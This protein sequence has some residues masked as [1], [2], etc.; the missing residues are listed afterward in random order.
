MTKN[1]RR[2]ISMVLA[3]VMVLTTLPANLFAV[4]AAEVTD[5]EHATAVGD[6]LVVKGDDST[7]PD[8][9]HIPGTH[10]EFVSKSTDPTCGTDIHVHNAG[11]YYK[12][13]DHK[14][15]HISTCYEISTAYEVCPD[16]D[17]HAHT[18][19]AN[20][21]DVV[22]INGTNVTWIT[23]H[24]AYPAVY[25]I[26]KAAYDEAY[27]SAPYLKDVAG[28]AAG[29]A[30]IATVT[31]CY[32]TTSEPTLC[33]HTCSELGGSCY[34]KTCIK[35][36]HAAHDDVKCYSY[37]WKL[38]YNT[39][40]PIKVEFEGTNP[41]VTVTTELP[42]SAKYND[43]ITF[44]LSATG[45]A[46][47]TWTAT[48][49]GKDPVQ[50]SA[51]EPTEVTA[52]NITSGTIKV[53]LTSETVPTYTIT[54][55][56]VNKLNGCAYT[57]NKNS[58]LLEGN[59][60]ELTVVIPTDTDS[61]KFTPSVTVSGA[62]AS[63]AGGVITVG[64]ENVTV[65]IDYQPKKLV[66]NNSSEASPVEIPYNFGKGIA[67]QEDAVKEAI[68]NALVNSGS[69]LPAGLTSWEQLSYQY[70]QQNKVTGSYAGESKPFTEGGTLQYEFA[71]IGGT[72]YGYVRNTAVEKIK[73]IWAEGNG[74]PEVF[75]DVYV[76]LADSRPYGEITVNNAAIGN[77]TADDASQVTEDAVRT[78]LSGAISSELLNKLAVTIGEINVV[79]NGMPALV[80][81]GSVTV[82]LTLPGTADYKQTTKTVTIT[83][84][85]PVYNPS[86]ILNSTNCVIKV[87]FDANCTVEVTE[88]NA[89]APGTY[90]AKVISVATGYSAAVPAINEGTL[91][92]QTNGSYSFT[93]EAADLADNA[94]TY[95]LTA[96]A[97]KNSYTVT[98]NPNGGNWS[99][100]A[101]NKVDTVEFEGTVTQPVDPTK[102][103]YTFAGWEPT[104]VTTMGAAN[105][106][107][108]AKWTVNEYTISFDSKG[109]PAV[110]GITKN[111]GESITLP[112]PA[113]WAGYTFLGWYTDEA[114]TEKF[115]GTTMPAGDAI[116]YAK[117]TEAESSISFNTNGGTAVE[118]IEGNYG[119]TVTKPADPTMIGYTFAGWYSD[120]DLT[121]PYTFSTLPATPITVYAKWN[122]NSYT[123]TWDWDG[124]EVGPTILPTSANYGE[125]VSVYLELFKTGHSFTDLATTPSNLN[126]TKTEREGWGG[127]DY[128]FTMPA[129]NVTIKATW[130]IDT[131]VITFVDEDGT[132]IL[133]KYEVEY[134]KMPTI[135]ADPAKADTAEW[136]YTFAGWDNEVVA[137]TGD[138]TYT[139]TYSAVKQEYT[140]TWIVNG[141]E[142]TTSVKY[143]DAAVAPVYTLPANHEFVKWDVTPDT[144]TGE[145]VY[146]AVLT[147]K[148]NGNPF[149]NKSEYSTENLKDKV[150]SALG[151]PTTGNYTV[152][153]Q[154]GAEIPLVGFQTLTVLVNNDSVSVQQRA[155]FD[156]SQIFAMALTNDTARTFTVTDNST[157]VAKTVSITVAEDRQTPAYT[158]GKDAF[159]VNADTVIDETWLKSNLGIMVPSA[160]GYSLNVVGEVPVLVA[161]NTYTVTVEIVIV[162][163]SDYTGLRETFDITIT[164][165]DAFVNITGSNN[166]VYNP[167]MSVEDI[168]KYIL[169]NLTVLYNPQ[170]LAQM[171]HSIKYLANEATT[172]PVTVNLKN[173]DLGAY[174]SLIPY[175][176]IT[177]DIPVAA[178]W[179]DIGA[180]YPETSAPSNEKLEGIFNDLITRY[181]VDLALGRIDVETLKAEFKAILDADEEL[182]LYYQYLAAHK[183]G[184]LSNETV[185]IIVDGGVYGSVTSNSFVID[186][187]DTRAETEIK[188]NSG[189]TVTYG[190]YTEAEL[191]AALLEGVYA[192]GTK[193]NADVV[194]VT[195]VIGLPASDAIEVTV[196]FKGNADYKP[197]AA[198]TTIVINK[199]PVSISVDNQIVKYGS[200]YNLLPV[201]TNPSNVDN[202]Q[203]VVGL[204]IS[205]VN[206]DPN[207]GASLGSI[208]GLVGSVQLLL[209]E[210]LQEMLEMADALLGLDGKLGYGATLKLSELKEYVTL[211]N[212][213]IPGY[214]EY[215][216]ILFKMLDTLPTETADIEVK[217]GGKLPS[218]IGVYLIGAVTADSNYETDFA[219]GV[220]AIYPDG[221]KVDLAWNQDDDNYIITNTLLSSGAF[222]AGAHAVKV[223]DDR[224]SLEQATAQ[225]GVIFLGVDIDGNIT[226]KM[227]QA[228]L[229]VGAY[230]EVAMIVNWGN[231][232]LY[233]EPLV[234][235]I[236]VVAEPLDVDFVDASGTV[237][238]DRHYEF[239]NVPQNGMEGSLLITYKQDGNGYK[240]GDIVTLPYEVTYYY[241]GVQTNGM[242]YASKIAPTHAGVYTITAMVVV[243]DSTG[244][245][246]HAGQGVGALVIEPSKSTITVENEAIKWDGNEHTVNGFVDAGS[247]NVPDITPDTTIISAGIFANLDANIGLDAIKGNVN[248]DMPVWLDNVIK[249]LGVLE[250]GYAEG[251]TADTFLSYV[252]KIQTALQDNGIEI[253]PFNKIVD[254]IKQLSGNTV[255]T[256]HDNK[257]YKDIGIYLVIGI[258]TDSDHYPSA[259]AGILV[260][261]P[262][263]EKV[264]LQYNKTWDNNNVFTQAY[265]QN[266]DLNA[267][268]FYNGAFSQS[269]TDKTINLFV[270]F[271]D[272]GEFILTSDKTALDNGIYAE[273]S[274]LLVLDNITYYAEPISREVIILP[275]NAEVDFTVN[276]EVNNDR[277]F[278]YNAQPHE[279]S[280]IRVTLA[281][282]TVLNL[283]QGDQGVAIYYVGV[284]SN[285]K[286]YAGCDAPVNAGVYE[287]TAQY[288]DRDAQGK[289]INLGIGVG[290]LVIEPAK[291][292]TTVDSDAIAWDGNEHTIGHMIHSSAVN[293]PGLRPDMT[294]ISAGLSAD[295]ANLSA[296]DAIT[297]TVNIDLPVW[298]DRIMNE[299][300]ILDAGYADGISREVLLNYADQIRVRLA[301]L[302]IE[303]ASFD[304]IIALVEQMPVNTNLT[305]LDDVA[306]DEIGAYLVIGIATD[307][308][309][310]PSVGAGLL[311]IYP[312]AVNAELNWFYN[313]I[314]GIITLP[315]LG[316][317]N[318][319]ANAY[320]D[321]VYSQADTEK[322]GYLIVGIDENGKL[323]VTTTPDDITS[324]GV[325]TQVAYMPFLLGS[326]ITMAKPIIRSFVVVPQTASV[327]ITDSKPTYGEDYNITVTVTDA[328]GAVSG[329]RLVNLQL[330]YVNAI[331]GY[332]STVAPTEVGTYA[333]I[334]TYVERINGD[335]ALIGMNTGSL[336]IVPADPDYEL[337]DKTICVGTTNSIDGMI[338]NTTKLPY[339]I[340][341]IKNTAK[342]EVNVILPAG[343]ELNLPVGTTVD[344]LIRA[345]EKLP[346]FIENAKGVD[347][348]KSILNSIDMQVLTINGNQPTEA[349]EYSVTSIAFGNRNY[350]I[351]KTQ[352]T[353]IIAHDVQFVQSESATCTD[354]GYE[355]YY[356]CMGCGKLFSDAALE[357]EIDSPIAIPATGH[358]ES[359]VVVENEKP[360]VGV[361][362][363]S[364]DN[365]TY[366][367][368]C[369]IELSRETII[370]PVKLTVKVDNKV[371]FVNGKMPELTYKVFDAN[372]QE[373]DVKLNL[374]LTCAPITGRGEYDIEAVL[375]ENPDCDITVENG[376]LTVLLLGDVDNDNDVD[377]DDAL[378]M[379]EYVA[380]VVGEE[381]LD[382][383]VADVDGNGVYD[384]DDA[385]LIQMYAALIIDI[386][387]A[388]V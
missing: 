193:I 48:I 199:A 271:A 378:L 105:V 286:Y 176:T 83:V 59:T 122:V 12:N 184:E 92:L 237:N 57:L 67:T 372:G 205:G 359:A 293:V 146:T 248:I 131:Y 197:S 55:V 188:L 384:L 119:D 47:H 164:V 319:S 8:P 137:V 344:E 264:D 97:T 267:Q 290:V 355:A 311:V 69:S 366:C 149:I 43:N 259:D 322:I 112:T 336:V 160:Q 22:T 81:T 89:V 136:D 18:N 204:D 172:V 327:D 111:Y 15:G 159:T 292:E 148:T 163:N 91:A 101:D 100:S 64:T 180:E 307:F 98:W 354:D 51:T 216:S 294:V 175:D 19:T 226:L 337:N 7:P 126:A 369:G 367:T 183:F 110:E 246:T 171:G 128:T 370:V 20:L 187:T 357:N 240:A 350:K 90:Y 10:W 123:I 124:G 331:T 54:V 218:N 260:I 79:P 377:L 25:A 222:D 249:K 167:E 277:H 38:V 42:E 34:L 330:I 178:L 44:T 116:L 31:V 262:D 62:G 305:F 86:I 280:T 135:P 3:F 373:L 312:K 189:V 241:V 261:Y 96:V 84:V 328:N 212:G 321:G 50:L 87:Y 150:L 345:I 174:A 347:E 380:L 58:N 352:A 26:Y 333:V 265:L 320:I 108:V 340:F 106:E 224:F 72:S 13:C 374:E 232:M 303:T 30:A 16:K 230:L 186:L 29:V 4:F 27:A 254:V 304:K 250:A 162:E 231:N 273:V 46:Y 75:A 314:N 195:D 301:D 95:T 356:K 342:G 192:N 244:Y 288:T 371:M 143:G 317:L 73:I 158:V 63:Y 156:V 243:R 88:L 71:E 297:G 360:S 229:N 211:L 238:N 351:A 14:D 201:I 65:T 346:D 206:L 140:I 155:D 35:T 386:F 213:K 139:A 28:K 281:D 341:I 177:V 387:P 129:E 223:Y 145:A 207:A 37:T 173:L 316:N 358:T 282:G 313:D 376:K 118:A 56:E 117:W 274:F 270:G 227:N 134:G 276:G 138:T 153:T 182:K 349:G 154:V 157:G 263:A 166:I 78:A 275:N 309:F 93:V 268:A 284:Q 200:D 220:L 1:V 287:V 23:T 348:L 353:L 5:H 300:G 266:Y 278:H 133:G 236:V 70:Y 375:G 45:D 306:Y 168:T 272:H 310:Y 161:G 252:N 234:R 185:K 257:G 60:A 381:A 39:L 194:F 52:K 114:L 191:L 24:P 152:T 225:V 61:F 299:L 219:V 283:K 295:P 109:G 256:F 334:A 209:P 296:L 6:T 208:K 32:T 379:Q 364:Y 279:M 228:N 169:E 165:N 318:M 151:L 113:A 102:E 235:P 17:N 53:V 247:V 82:I 245:I 325:Y 363:G 115:V 198:T 308:N 147:L 40:T 49:N 85:N 239:F 338:V 179:L 33:T 36:E 258:V 141:V 217:L 203:F 361:T 298:M 383:S 335:I 326:E 181:G 142:Q 66:V 99:G 196:K 368:V 289:V 269:L 242:P 11:C 214:E 329:D 251:I 385:L 127:Y 339:A 132:T 120:E 121:T 343:W 76:K 302:G 388:E 41:G 190:K 202:I 170:E 21:T 233:A 2:I 77:I 94:K 324:L 210:E 9:A 107:Y 253:D 104:V 291:T 315:A 255:L 74:L 382:L 144:V 68:F 80:T 332:Y 103:G 365:V 323:I 362:P 221:T 130:T 125:T 215:F 285:G